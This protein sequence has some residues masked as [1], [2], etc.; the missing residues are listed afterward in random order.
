MAGIYQA[1]IFCD[2]C[3][4]CIKRRIA[5][6]SFDDISRIGL[7]DGADIE[8]GFESVADLADYLDGMD[9]RLYDSDAYPKYCSGNEES[10][11]PQHCGGCGEFMENQLTSDGNDYV[12]EAV[13]ESRINGEDNAVTEEWAAY[14]SYLDF[15][16]KCEECG[17]FAELDCTT[18]GVCIT[19]EENYDDDN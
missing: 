7:P 13:N 16:E 8:D 2:D 3:T 17:K 18:Y 12:I 11:C 1:D 5:E 14:Y 6:D 15:H 19:C 4:D 10:D 9:E